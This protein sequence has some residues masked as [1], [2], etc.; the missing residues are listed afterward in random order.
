M[1]D[2]QAACRE[3]HRVRVCV[4]VCLKQ[5]EVSECFFL[6]KQLLRD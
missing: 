6:P 2:H 3:F 1:D 5:V 4:Y